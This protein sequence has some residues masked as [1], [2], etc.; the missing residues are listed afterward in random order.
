MKTLKKV[1]VIPDS[2]KGT[3]SSLEVCKSMKEAIHKLVP[4]CNVLCIPV[5][6]GGEGTVDCFLSAIPKAKKVS[7][8][9]TGPFEEPV[10]CYY[11]VTGNTAIIEMAQ[12]AGLPLA[13]GRLNPKAATSYGVGEMIRH[14]VEVSGCREIIIGLGGSCTNDAGVGCA[15]ALG[16]TFMDADGRSFVPTPVTLHKIASFDSSGAGKLLEH[17]TITAMCDIQNPMH[18]EQGAAYVFA[19]QKGADQGCVKE[20]DEN[21]AA[22]GGVM[23]KCL[24]R[25]VASIPGAGAAG[26]MGAG[27]VA[28]LNG[29]LKSGID[30]V[31][32]L[33]RFEEELADA[34]LVFT[35][36]G[37]I[38]AQSLGGK[39]V[40]GIARRAREHKVPVIAVVGAIG[41]GAFGAYE[42]GVNAIFSINTAAVDF[43]IARW[44]SRENLGVTMENIVRVLGV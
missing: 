20:L 35:G 7:L 4:D 14:G 38:D 6:D 36:E 13:E 17:C 22:L 15:R 29:Q 10:D 21:L 41:E 37:K 18:G 25:D 5:A 23:E 26:A 39:V 27:I 31:L 11:A 44:H 19:P 34:D 8:T 32:D 9:V 28:F 40:V 24:G 3:M 16:V 30:T 2:F 43:E 12:A 42:L 33:V 1:I